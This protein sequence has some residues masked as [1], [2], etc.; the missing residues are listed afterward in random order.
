M[1]KAKKNHHATGEDKTNID[2]LNLINPYAHYTK[3]YK[4]ITFGSGSGLWLDIRQSLFLDISESIT[5]YLDWS[6]LTNYTNLNKLSQ[7]N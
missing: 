6:E 4:T 5:H 3:L 7:M 2:F 1:V